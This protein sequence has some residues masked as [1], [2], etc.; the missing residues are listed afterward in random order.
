MDDGDG[1]SVLPVT[2]KLPLVTVPS[3]RSKGTANPSPSLT[4]STVSQ[5][6]DTTRNSTF[7]TAKERKAL[8]RAAAL[9][10]ASQAKAKGKGKEKFPPI[11][12][13]Q[14]KD[15]Q[16]GDVVRVVGRLDEWY[17]RNTH[18]VGLEGGGGEWV[19]S[20]VVDE[21]AGGSIGMFGVSFQCFIFARLHSC[22]SEMA[23]IALAVVDPD[24]Q[25]DHVRDVLH[26]R[27]TVY[28]R[29]FQIPSTNI[30]NTAIAQ[31]LP[32]PSSS[33]KSLPETQMSS[34]IEPSSAI[35]SEMS[36]DM[37]E[38]RVSETVHHRQFH[39]DL[40]LAQNHI[41]HRQCQNG[42][43]TTAMRPFPPP[44][45]PA[46]RPHIQDLLAR[47]SHPVDPS[48]FARD[49]IAR[50]G[51]RSGSPGRRVPGVQGDQSFSA[52]YAVRLHAS[53]QYED[54]AGRSVW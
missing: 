42:L 4:A 7:L 35:Y 52:Q 34:F 29:P 48:I 27:R 45:L 36:V 17:R 16:V 12:A 40:L 21:G 32:T 8:R 50:C 22:Q 30:P 38:L 11:K 49:R 39:R 25:F 3:G 28:S 31:S 18:S 1:R 5:S 24:D 15:V 23:D 41:L 20:V 26:L 37:D 47:P 2:V 10:D 19:R 44:H 43:L 51:C 6:V 14:R 54:T 13:Y 53:R 46:Y 9:E 33:R